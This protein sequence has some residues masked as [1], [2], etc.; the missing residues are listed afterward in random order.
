MSG[1]AYKDATSEIEQKIAKIR[2]SP[3]GDGELADTLQEAVDA[4]R[5]SAMR[6]SHP[7]AVAQW[8]P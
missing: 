8:T 4:L 6:N 2:R 1:P 7:D 3:S 5:G